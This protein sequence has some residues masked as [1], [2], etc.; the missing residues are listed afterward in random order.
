MNTWIFEILGDSLLLW[1]V[2]VLLQWTLVTAAALALCAFLRRQP[3]VRYGVL[4]SGLLLVLFVPLIA[5]AMQ[6]VGAGVL[7]VAWIDDLPQTANAAVP[8]TPSRLEQVNVSRI[9]NDAK[10]A[11]RRESP[12]ETPSVAT[13]ANDMAATYPLTSPTNAYASSSATGIG[14]L[15]R[16][17]MP[18]FMGFWL[19]GTALLLVRLVMAWRCLAAILRST[20]PTADEALA[21][22]FASAAKPSGAELMVSDRVSGPLAAGL[23]RPRVVFPASLVGRLTLEQTHAILVHELAHVSRRDQVIVLLQNVAG[24]LGWLHP[25]IVLLNRQLAQAREEV[26]DNHVLADIEAPSYGRTLLTLAQ[27]IQTSRPLP[28]SVGFFTSQWTLESRVAG[29]LDKGRS[30]ATCLTVRGKMVVAALAVVLAG[31]AALGTVERTAGQPLEAQAADNAGAKNA[32]IAKAS[33]LV[34]GRIANANGEPVAGAFVAIVGAN[35]A[36]GNNG[37][38]LVEGMADGAGHYELSLPGVSSTTHRDVS[39]IARADKL[40]L[41]WQRVDL[42]AA[43][44]RIDLKLPQEQLLQVRLIDL[45]GKPVANLAVDIT[46]ISS[47]ERKGRDSSGIGFWLM[48]PLPRNA[49]PRPRTDAGGLLSIPGIPDDHSVGLEVVPTEQ[50]ARQQLWLNS[51]EPE[52]RPAN[53]GTYRPI[54]KKVPPEQIVTIPL[55]SATIFEGVV[56]LADTGMPAANSVIKI[57]ASQ[58]KEFGSMLWIDGKTDDRGRFRLNPYTGIRFGISAYP[59]ADT[60]FFPRQ[61]NDLHWKPLDGSKSIEIRLPAAVLAS[62]TVVDAQS[63][64]PVVGASVQYLAETENNKYYTEDIVMGWQNMQ[65][66]DDQGR[67]KITVPPPGPGTILVHAPA[68]ASY[69]LREKTESEIR[70]AKVG[71]RRYYAHAFR[72][73]APPVPDAKVVAGP[74]AVDAIKLQPGE[75]VVAK[76]LDPDGK[77]I[78]KALAIS[79]LRILPNSLYFRGLFREEAGQAVAIRGLEKGKRYPV[80]FLDAKRRL[81]TTALISSDDPQPTITLQPCASAKMRLLKPDGTPVRAGSYGSLLMVVTPG[82]AGYDL[83]NLAALR[84]DEDFVG[85]FDQLNYGRDYVTDKNG[86]CIAPVLIPGATYRLIDVDDVKTIIA[87]EF[88]AEAGKMHDLGNIQLRSKQ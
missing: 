61:T 39:L 27:W 64:T 5:A 7:S 2:N 59:P 72:S 56:L 36:K 32:G 9:V 24:A 57:W 73:I 44:S 75:N 79:R 68:S 20:R 40:A 84:A 81:G 22:A 30:R 55:A 74:F 29:L 80:H 83:D 52:E 12:S 45:Q 38:T 67:Y 47:V 85:N 11:S 34:K 69:V 31:I 18:A 41:A 46:G 53:D 82:A 19:A 49:L 28:G 8:T 60:P 14:G 65:Y 51:D 10:D 54:I 13:T 78:E 16:A 58:Q 15:V 86:V 42:L 77:A 21:A 25:L 4:C 50:I 43:E 62:G 1:G 3:A 71:G 88:V 87:K 26:C 70:A 48:D 6:G 63:G 37:E 23:W 33:I 17:S 35:I 76:L 66:T